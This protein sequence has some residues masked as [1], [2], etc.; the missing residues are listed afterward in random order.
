M[1][2]TAPEG[3]VWSQGLIPTLTPPTRLPLYTRQ[4]KTTLTE[5]GAQD[6][7]NIFFHLEGI[8]ITS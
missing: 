7:I 4:N 3:P 5:T 2:G 6:D 1:E 8:E